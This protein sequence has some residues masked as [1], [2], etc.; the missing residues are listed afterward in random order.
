MCR[1]TGVTPQE[2][3]A[4]NSKTCTS[5]EFSRNLANYE[6]VIRFAGV[7]THHHNAIAKRNI[8]TIMAIARTLMMHSAIHCPD[9]T[10]PTCGLS[11]SSMLCS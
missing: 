2:H 4:D 1:N 9:V 5:A 3:L 10:D 8:L 11:Q 7:G 6:Q